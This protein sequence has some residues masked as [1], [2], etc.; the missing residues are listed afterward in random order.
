MYS[1]LLVDKIAL[2]TGGNSGIGLGTARRLIDAGAFVYITGRR[3]D[4]LDRAQAQLGQNAKA[5]QADVTRKADMERVADTI[6]A[7]KGRLDIVFANAGG[8]G[9]ISLEEITE[10]DFDRNFAVDVK[11]VLFTV[12]TALPLMSKGSSIVLNTSITSF[13]GLPRFSVYAAAKAAVGSFTKTWANELRTRGIRVNA[14][15][16]GVVPTEGY[17]KDLGW[18]EDY[19]RQYKDRVSKEI[20]VGRVGTVD[21]IGNAV[22]YLS[23]QMGSFV[24]GVELT[25]DGGMTQ[26]YQGRN[27]AE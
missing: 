6:R 9:F 25:V 18:S 11:G 21:D 26:I 15:A 10:E 1:Q 16:P 24:N 5:I 27:G 8:G 14:V 20:L 4:A 17:G 3:K 22:V 19:V 12:Q 23:S 13:M 7:D 2:V